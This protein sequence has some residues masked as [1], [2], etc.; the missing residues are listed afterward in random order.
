MLISRHETV[1]YAKAICR[2]RILFSLTLV[3]VSIAKRAINQLAFHNRIV[4]KSKT[5]IP[6]GFLKP[7]ID[8]AGCPLALTNTICL[9]CLKQNSSYFLKS[10][11]KFFF[12]QLIDRSDA[13]VAGP[14]CAYTQMS[15]VDEQDRS[16]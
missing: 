11:S 12:F 13:I 10:N 3:P 16:K 7:Q 9:W 6:F 2:L 4:N 15:L 1:S 14:E 8:M 5:F